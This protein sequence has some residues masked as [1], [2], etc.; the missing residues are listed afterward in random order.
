MEKFKNGFTL[1]KWIKDVMDGHKINEVKVS[2][3]LLCFLVFTSTPYILREI[4]VVRGV[5]VVFRFLG[6]GGVALICCCKKRKWNCF[7]FMTLL[8]CTVIFISALHAGLSSEIAV[9]ATF[10]Y[11]HGAYSRVVLIVGQLCIIKIAFDAQEKICLVMMKTIYGY[12]LVLCLINL[13]TQILGLQVATKDGST[14]FLGFDNDMGKYYLFAFF[15]GCVVMVLEEKGFSR[16]LFFLSALTMFEGI[17]RKIGVLSA[18]SILMIGLVLVFFVAP[19]LKIW[20]LRQ[21]IFLGTMIG[22]YMVVMG[23]YTRLNVLQT[24]IDHY[25]YG[26]AGSLGNRFLLQTRF[27]AKWLES[28]LWGWASVLNYY[29][30]EDSLSWFDYALSRGQTHNYFIETLYNFGFFA[31]LLFVLLLLTGIKKMNGYKTEVS[32][33]GIAFLLVIFRGM[34]ENGSHEIFAVLPTLYYLGGWCDKRYN[35]VEDKA[36]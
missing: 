18:I 34:F 17:Y 23:L 13:M 5:F 35:S 2:I 8:F 24:F 1:S 20:K 10:T 28:P 12:Y 9:N 30:W 3:L 32:F 19:K 36:E 11:L 16:R 33:V 7:D 15:Y 14:F 25:L 26:K 4:P 21:D 6:A 22:V 27:L 31:F 29:K